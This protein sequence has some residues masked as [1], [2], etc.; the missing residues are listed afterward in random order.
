MFFFT[1]KFAQARSSQKVNNDG[2][3]I[4]FNVNNT[5]IHLQYEVYDDENVAKKN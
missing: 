2:V 4:E 5:F 3:K 1:L